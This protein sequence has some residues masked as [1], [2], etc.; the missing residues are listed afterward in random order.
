[1]YG[2][3]MSELKLI[4]DEEEMKV[5][6]GE[7][8]MEY[9]KVIINN[10]R[11]RLFLY[12]K[13]FHV[14]KLDKINYIM[15]DDLEEFRNYNLVN[16]GYKNPEYSRGLFIPS[17]SL[18][19]VVIDSEIRNDRF[20]LHKMLCSN[21]HE[22]FHY[23]YQKYIYKDSKNRVIWFDE[24]MAQNLSGEYEFLTPEEQVRFFKHWE[25]HYIPIDNLN[26]RIQGTKDVPDN[27]IFKRQGV[28][29]GYLTSYFIVK[30]IYETRGI[31]GL[32]EL[33]FDRDKVLEVGNSNIIEEM[34]EYYLKKYGT[35]VL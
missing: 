35:K 13:V 12:K 8:L 26:D 19:L 10:L 31:K 27:L 24:G 22:A 11:E 30:Y 4:C 18:S 16:Y 33:M 28:F 23:Y 7:S 3:S 21:S 20:K 34:R 25:H 9:Q 32:D 14:D 6:I 17:A 15:F 2:D 29:D 1:M 5:S